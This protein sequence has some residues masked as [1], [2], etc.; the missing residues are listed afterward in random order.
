MNELHVKQSYFKQLDGLRFV[1]VLAIMAVHW[2][3][4]PAIFT[5]S[6]IASNISV[7]LYFVLSG[8]LITR[9]LLHHKIKIAAGKSTKLI[10]IKNFYARR[11]LRIFPVYY[12]LIFICIVLNLP[13]A[14]DVYP[15]LL[16]YTTN[17]LR[18]YVT[19]LGPFGHLW[20][21]AIEEQFYLVF[22]FFILW[23]PQQFIKKFLIGGILLALLSRYFAVYVFQTPIA[24]YVF[25]FCCADALCIG[26][27]LAYALVHENNLQEILANKIVLWIAILL[28]VFCSY[29]FICISQTDALAFVWFRLSISGFCVWIIGYGILNRYSGIIKLFLEHRIIMYLGKICYGIYLFHFLAPFVAD[30]LYELFP[31]YDPFPRYA[32]FE[33]GLVYF[34][35]TVLMAAISWQWIEQ[36]INNLKKR[37]E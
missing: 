34:I 10:S 12:L 37:F 14:R 31:V 19:D 22:P 11:S 3:K 7:D 17:F 9:I 18:L 4:I 25:P 29:R 36:P 1:A 21:L 33:K 8:F 26:G 2:L 35:L 6:A 27:L 32:I 20:T 5:Y 15:W 16:T 30:Y 28:F 23:L 13:P 24:V